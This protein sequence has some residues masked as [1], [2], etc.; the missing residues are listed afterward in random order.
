MRVLFFLA[1]IV[2]DASFVNHTRELFNDGL[3]VEFVRFG[4]T[5]KGKMGTLE[6]FFHILGVTTETA[7]GGFALI[8]LDGTDW[9]QG[10]LVAK[11]KIHGLVLDETIGFKTVLVANFMIEQGR[12][13]HLGNDVEPLSKNIIQK[14]KTTSFGTNHKAFLGTITAVAHSLLTAST[15]G[16][17]S[18]D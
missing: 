8:E 2:E 4:D 6:E 7:V 10:L 17:P 13:V 3:A 9:A 11:N 1:F 18:Y 14:L 16:N 12:N 15:S 5:H